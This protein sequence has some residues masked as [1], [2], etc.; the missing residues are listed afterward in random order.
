VHTIVN[1]GFPSCQSVIF[2]FAESR[3]SLY[4]AQLLASALGGSVRMRVDAGKLVARAC[5]PCLDPAEVAARRELCASPT[6]GT[7]RINPGP[8]RDT[9]QSSSTQG[10]PMGLPKIESGTLT[11]HTLPKFHPQVTDTLSDRRGLTLSPGRT[12]TPGP[13]S[14]YL[15]T[16]S[17][18]D[19][20]ET[21]N[22]LAIRSPADR[23]AL[24]MHLLI[25]D[26]ELSNV[27]I[28]QRISDRIGCTNVP[29]DDGIHVV[30]LLKSMGMISDPTIPGS[31]TSDPEK[32]P[33]PFDAILL[34][35]VMRS[36]DGAE[37]CKMLREQ[38][39]VTIP[40]IAV[41]A[42]GKDI[43]YLHSCG[44]NDVVHKPV[45]SNSVHT[46]LVN[47]MQTPLAGTGC[48]PIA[49]YM[50]LTRGDTVDNR[51]SS[52]NNN[53]A[54]LRVQTQDPDLT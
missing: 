43:P 41:T 26:D 35:L 38:Y 32:L 45:N 36:S 15:M 10:S 52:N 7:G 19:A 53:N 13:S 29:L 5:I 6:A 34:D 46:A 18:S 42:N 37:V 49:A 25:V 31:V 4:Q 11:E 3:F 27:R 20:R 33:R 47:V 51:T 8:C 39:K 23:P 17:V 12:L 16:H 54:G 40:I 30:P 2:V 48:S 21:A 50:K 44:F 9:I 28:L 22:G 1:I 14:R 24:R